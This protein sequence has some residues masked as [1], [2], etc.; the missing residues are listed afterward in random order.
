MFHNI[1]RVGTKYFFRSRSWKKLAIVN[2]IRGCAGSGFALKIQ[3]EPYQSGLKK[4]RKS[5]DKLPN[6]IVL[7]EAQ[8]ILQ[9][10]RGT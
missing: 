8:Y 7:A 5:D 4:L 10:R 2:K 1:P 3:G 9:K 6:P